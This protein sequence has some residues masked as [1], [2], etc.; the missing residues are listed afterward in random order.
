MPKHH[1]RV[2]RLTEM[3]DLSQREAAAR[4][5]CREGTLRSRHHRARDYLRAL[6]AR[7]YKKD[8]R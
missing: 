6:F 8:P 1:S 3:E 4:M 5:R 2:L 7:L